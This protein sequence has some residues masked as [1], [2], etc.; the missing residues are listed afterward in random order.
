MNGTRV[1][2]NKKVIN[3]Y[4]VLNKL[5]QQLGLVTCADTVLSGLSGGER[6]RLA[7]AVQLLKRP[8]LLL[9]D[10]PTSGID[11]FAC[12]SLLEMLAD[13]AKQAGLTVITTLHAPRADVLPFISRLLVLREGG[14]VTY[15]G[16]QTAL[17]LYL[18]NL[19]FVCPST[20]NPLDF[21][22]DLSSLQ[23][24]S[25]VLA[26]AASRSDLKLEADEELMQKYRHKAITT[27]ANS[28]Y[29][30]QATN[31][32]SASVL[33]CSSLLFVL[34]N[35]QRGT[36]QKFIASLML[37]MKRGFIEEYRHYSTPFALLLQ[38]AIVSAATSSK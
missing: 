21:V 14:R 31:T 30:D 13:V 15:S 12:H 2:N 28:R 7:V 24:S 4:E 17:L 10:E 23:A 33:S 26:G 16:R 34:V 32:L 11:A 22:V 5:L 1:L 18:K 9:L 29:A 36:F 35:T 25:D 3:D 8:K 27:N 20:A 37:L 6:R 19:N 38:F